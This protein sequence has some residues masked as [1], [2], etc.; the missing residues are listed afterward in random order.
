VT[1]PRDPN[2]I[3]TEVVSD[4]FNVEKGVI[5]LAELL[6]SVPVVGPGPGGLLHPLVKV[7]ALMVMVLS[8]SRPKCKVRTMALV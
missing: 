1:P 8:R 4:S 7:L 5:H 6:I 2:T 3:L